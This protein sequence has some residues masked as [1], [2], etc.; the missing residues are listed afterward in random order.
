MTPTPPP[1]P[2]SAPPRPIE[3]LLPTLAAAAAAT[4]AGDFLLWPATP[5]ISL[6]IFVAVL[7]ALLLAHRASKGIG[8]RVWFAAAL[9][10]GASVQATI[11]ICLTNVAVLIALLLVLIGESSFLK[12]PAGWARWWEAFVAMLA[13]PGRW[14]WL[15]GALSEQPVLT[16]DKTARAG[17]GIV[18]LLRIAAPAVALAVIFTIVL[19]QGNAI[20]SQLIARGW[21]GFSEWLMSFDFTVARVAFWLLLATFALAIFRPAA[22]PDAAR[23]FARMPGVWVRPDVTV[24]RWQSLSVLAVLNAIFFTVNTIDVLYLWRAGGI[25]EN[26][27]AYEFIHEGTNSL[28]TATVLSA[29]VLAAIF[30]QSP[31]VS[32]GRGLRVLSYAWIV[33][34]LV[35]L[36]GVCLRWKFYLDT[37]HVLTAKRIHLACFLALVALGFVFL[38]LHIARGPDLRRLLWRNA[39]ATFVL[40]YVLQFLN[41]TGFAAHWNVTQWQNIPGRGLDLNYHRKQGE[42]AWPA[43]VRVARSDV[44][45]PVVE[46]AR[47]TVRK[48]ADAERTRLEHQDWREQQLRRDRYARELIAATRELP[49]H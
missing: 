46:D 33:Q 20:F 12:L 5:G 41:T 36:A 21:T 45:G 24:A 3:P 28:I 31:E 14:F 29:L 6:A 22:A 34:N 25:S 16:A 26:V 13:A 15:I 10:L 4:L 27:N 8:P 18:R 37:T 32:R 48:R 1:L 17:G 38:T 43:L 49:P 19:G 7:A 47:K 23:A 40:F 42:N 11:E 30:Q 9:L 39:V 35:L 2:A 44:G